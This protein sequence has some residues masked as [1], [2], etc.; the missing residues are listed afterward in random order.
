M[1]VVDPEIEVIDQLVRALR[2]LEHRQQRRVI[3]YLAERFDVYNPNQ[4]D[5][6]QNGIGN[7]CDPDQDGDGVQNSCG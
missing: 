6:N 7:L 5:I 1:S 2:G 4:S 3:H